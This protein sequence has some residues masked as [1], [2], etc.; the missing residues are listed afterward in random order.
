V[1]AARAARAGFDETTTRMRLGMTASEWR[2]GIDELESAH[3]V[4]R[5][6]ANRTRFVS[7]RV[8]NEL[9]SEL[10]KS[11]D[12]FHRASPIKGG[13][14]IVALTQKLHVT[15]SD[16]MSTVLKHGADEKRI[17]LL[18]DRVSLPG[19]AQESKDATATLRD[20][21]LAF[22][23]EHGL[24]APRVREVADALKVAAKTV[25]ELV[26]QE[27]SG[28]RLVRI[29]ADFVAP[30]DDV[31]ALEARLVDH[32]AR[33]GSI[34]TQEFKDLSGVTRK[35]A[36]PLAEFFDARRLTLRVGEKRI[37]R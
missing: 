31:K 2:T 11:L 29:A 28:G 12:A 22:Y 8:I 7:M 10:E 37:R 35:Y 17:E 1:V 27:I 34:S 30:L 4:T 36:I 18:Q 23:G 16:V 33:H 13:E 6:N 21:I 26:A 14:S 24:S 32:L 20:A 3:L 5:L 19:R 15:S 25:E 9:L